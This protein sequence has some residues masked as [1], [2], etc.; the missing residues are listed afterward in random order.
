MFTLSWISWSFHEANISRKTYLSSC[1]KLICSYK[2]LMTAWIL[3]RLT[4]TANQV[5]VFTTVLQVV[6]PLVTPALSRTRIAT[7]PWLFAAATPKRTTFNNATT[8][9][10]Q[11]MLYNYSIDHHAHT[12]CK[13]QDLRYTHQ[14]TA[15]IV[16][17]KSLSSHHSW[18]QSRCQNNSHDTY[19]ILHHSSNFPVEHS[20]CPSYSS[21]DSLQIY[22]HIF[23]MA[24]PE[25]YL[26]AAEQQQT[27]SHSAGGKVPPQWKQCK[28]CSAWRNYDSKCVL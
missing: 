13:H 19:G 27:I 26:Y 22:S 9:M 2:L 12:L 5:N 11:M 18:F 8:C 17:Q 24:A 25:V 7:R 4:E 1:N 23:V 28:H 16:Q 6:T 3:F 20:S 21:Y 10:D 15:E 14:K